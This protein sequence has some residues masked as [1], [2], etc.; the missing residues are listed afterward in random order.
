MLGSDLI[1]KF[2]EDKRETRERLTEESEHM[3]AI[4]IR[5]YLCRCVLTSLSVSF[6]CC[7]SHLYY[8]IPSASPLTLLPSFFLF[9]IYL[10]YIYC[11]CCSPSRKKEDTLRN[12]ISC[13]LDRPTFAVQFPS[14]S[15]IYGV[16]LS[17]HFIFVFFQE[18]KLKS[19]SLYP[20]ND[21]S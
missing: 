10:V 19:P 4:C 20:L 15:G 6:R 1:E 2:C 17:L 9:Y 7:L 3:Q 5:V 13:R 12:D 18:L 21:W 14:L 16:S 11:L 8:L